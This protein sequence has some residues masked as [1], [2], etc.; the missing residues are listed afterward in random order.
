MASCI[1]YCFAAHPLYALGL[2]SANEFAA[3]VLIQ[4]DHYLII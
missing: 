3:F 4:V 1:A 2:L